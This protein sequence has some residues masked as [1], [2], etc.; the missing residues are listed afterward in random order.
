MIE[1]D[2]MN[3]WI[4][5]V[6]ITAGFIL[7]VLGL[8]YLKE[9]HQELLIKILLGAIAIL[10]FIGMANVIHSLIYESILNW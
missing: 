7:F 6:F 1:W 2:T 8:F 9:H 10:V 3:E 4:S 5:S